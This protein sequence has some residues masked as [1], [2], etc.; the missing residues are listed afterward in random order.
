MS[1]LDKEI[2]AMKAIGDRFKE[3][4]VNEIRRILAWAADKFIPDTRLV[5]QTVP[6]EPAPAAKANSSSAGFTFT[7]DPSVSEADFS[8]ADATGLMAA[9]H[10]QMTEE[11]SE[12]SDIFPAPNSC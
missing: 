8:R 12:D 11:N 7:R 3:L 4:D 6:A 5:A 10:W 9:A 2:E 1:D